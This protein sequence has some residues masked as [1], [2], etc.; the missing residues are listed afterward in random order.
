MLSVTILMIHTV[1][2]S[3]ALDY[4]LDNVDGF[5]KNKSSCGPLLLIN[6]SLMKSDAVGLRRWGFGRGTPLV[7]DYLFTVLVIESGVTRPPIP[8]HL[9]CLL[10]KPPPCKTRT[11][12][13]IRSFSSLSVE[14]L[15]QDSVCI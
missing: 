5:G 14:S 7:L 3:S 6:C 10:F 15:I 1:I 8:I 4:Y 13:S 2:M 12:S 11:G 9:H